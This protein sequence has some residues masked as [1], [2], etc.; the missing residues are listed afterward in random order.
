[1]ISCGKK[2]LNRKEEINPHYVYDVGQSLAHLTFQ[3]MY[4]GL[5][6]HQMGGFY[7]EKA[8]R[9]FGIPAMFKPITAT[10]IGY[11]GDYNILPKRMQRTELAE[12]KRMKAADFVFSGVFGNKSTLY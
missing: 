5:Y 6:V 2:V 4:E 12:R 11:I 3:A 8:V 7:P 9:I 10:A 1:M